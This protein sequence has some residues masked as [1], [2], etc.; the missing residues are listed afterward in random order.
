MDLHT[1]NEMLSILNEM[2]R[3]G[4]HLYRHIS[5][6]DDNRLLSRFFEMQAAGMDLYRII[7]DYSIEEPTPPSIGCFNG[8]GDP[9][10]LTWYT[11]GSCSLIAGRLAEVFDT[12]ENT[13]TINATQLRLTTCSDFTDKAGR[14]FKRSEFQPWNQPR[15]WWNYFEYF[16]G[17]CKDLK[18]TLLLDVLDFNT[19]HLS[20]LDVTSMN[21]SLLYYFDSIVERCAG[22]EDWIIIGANEYTVDGGPSVRWCKEFY[23][24]FSDKGFKVSLYDKLP[25]KAD[26]MHIHNNLNYSGY[27]VPIM[28][29]EKVDGMLGGEAAYY[30]YV[31][32][33][34][35][36]VNKNI[37][38][39][40]SFWEWA[41]FN[42]NFAPNQLRAFKE[43]FGG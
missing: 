11:G 18:L 25:F 9:F 34:K 43:V 33:L 16:I 23:K 19:T 29:E 8:I 7:S 12:I 10:I 42:E 31:D 5:G 1:K 13:N 41:L 38:V 30:R 6:I 14:L 39:I 22:M 32:F 4:S 21:S 26:Y 36:A 35:K 2:Y 27:T 3:Y 20:P 28:N 24:Y 37:N 40:F 17:E 15:K